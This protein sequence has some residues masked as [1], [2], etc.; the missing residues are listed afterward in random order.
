[1]T[2][3]KGNP[4]N[5]IFKLSKKGETIE[6]MKSIENIP[7]FFKYI[8]DEKI[9]SESRANVINEFIKKLQVNRYI[10]EFFSSFENESIYF[11]LS[12]IYLNST[13]KEVLKS[14]ILNLIAELRINLDI[15][16][17]IYDYLFQK[18]SLIYRSEN[19]LGKNDLHE[20]LVLLDAFLGETI[21]SLKPKN[22]FTC[23]GKGYFEVDLSKLK[24]NVG[25]SFSFILNFKLGTSA[26][27]LENPAACSKTT[28]I[29]IHFSNGHNINIDF[30]YPMF[31]LVKEIQDKYIKTL[32]VLE[33]M[34]LII[35]IVNDD[36]NNTVAYFY[37]NGENRLV[38]F[39]FKNQKIAKTD[40][41]DSIKFFNNFYGEV[42]S[43]TFLSQK[44]Y[45]FPG[46]NASEFLL[47]FKT[48]QEGYWKRKK[49]NNLIN[50]LNDF[51]SIGIEKT[52]SKTI[53]NKRPVKL[54]K[55]IEK[56]EAKVTGKLSNNLV[57]IFT[58]MN[59]CSN[60]INKN[61][62]E[63]VLGNLV[64]KFYG[65]IRPHKYYCFQ[66]RIGTLG[67][68][69]NILP[70]G[71]MFVLRPE[72]LDESN[73]LIFLGIIKDILNE[74]KHNMKYL[75]ESSFF[76]V[77]SL[78][79]EKYPKTFFTEKV[80]DEFAEIGKCLLAGNVESVTSLYF[81][82]ILLNE[83]IL[84]KYSEPLQIK[85]WN[86]ILLFCQ[87]DSSQIEVFIKM[88]RIALILRFYDRNKYNA[89]CC[90]R[91]ME[92]IKDEFLVNKTIMDP[93]MNQK[94]SSIQNILNVIISSQEPDK[95]FLLFKLLTLDLSP[96]LTEFILNIFINEF[97]KR[98]EDTSNW[99]DRFIN[100]LIENKYQA[101]IANTF[102]HSLPELK[103]SLLTLITEINS[104]LVKLNKAVH[105][106]AIEDIIMQS[107][108]PQDNFYAKSKIDKSSTNTNTNSN[109]ANSNTNIAKTNINNNN[110]KKLMN[111]TI[112]NSKAKDLEEKVKVKNTSKDD[113]QE[114]KKMN[115]I[116]TKKMSNLISQFELMKNKIPGIAPPKPDLQKTA[117]QNQEHLQKTATQNPEQ[118][119]QQIKN[120][121][122]EIPDNN[123]K[124][125]Y[126]NNK[127]E[128]IIFNDKVY[129]EYVEKLYELL[130]LWAVN[131]VQNTI[132]SQ[133]D[134]KKLTVESPIALEFLL[135]LAL[136]I[137]DILFYIKCIR[138]IHFLSSTPINAYK[139]LLNP[140]IVC[141]LSDIIFKYYKAKDKKESQCFEMIK[142][143]LLNI[144]MNNMAY[145]ENNKTLSPYPLDKV[146]FLFL[147][148]DKKIFQIKTKNQKDQVL[149]FLNDFLLEFLTTFKIKY[150]RS[151]DLNVT[152]GN[153]Q[154]SPTNFYLKNYLI[155]MTH[156]FKFSFHYKHDEIIKTEGLTF[157][158]QSP[159]INNYLLFYLTGMR[160]NPLK[161]EKMI[162]QWIDYP[163][164]DDMYR[165]FS[166]IINI[167]YSTSI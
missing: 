158:A 5:E 124:L 40:T 34:N 21:N 75:A 103:I 116:S 102:L 69:N 50:L 146:D 100:V 71:E 70:I 120:L 46:V 77:L 161:G 121:Y 114:L 122:E 108:L 65:N 45:G 51:D 163:F 129:F 18:L 36:K 12:K 35:N 44:D 152:K 52:K 133:L 25:C 140:K 16:K 138:I 151:M 20:Y 89:I 159:G 95:A 91:H 153:M 164:F 165:R 128:V 24:L 29:D 135:S 84:L 3:I 64:L 127:G 117:T 55:K 31:L 30:E 119:S 111:S 22:Y 67:I 82:H 78:F 38:A 13:S 149:D 167:I 11:I 125:N 85:F 148:G 166:F 142:N 162:E 139:M 106:K 15:N 80:L 7:L 8:K 97:Q 105:F 6:E 62:V 27:A 42:S 49:I 107:L 144:F 92:L 145:S 99:K 143:I 37:T 83:K 150:E 19:N 94:L 47:Q 141:F 54:E 88:N 63:N 4:L 28:L 160:L 96:C 17:N 130:L 154:A 112:V 126:E 98:K 33:W 115:T 101:I 110:A 48:Y 147:W 23:S 74:R 57:F 68:I 53:F 58:P 132:I 73:F 113:S 76:E 81:E 90:K 109:N 155:L 131:Q 60:D 136:D 66:K 79:V 123:Y 157:I 156:F 1:M 93:P 9:P 72:L 134:F 41:I 14:S 56:E 61:V 10:S 87:L 26:L 104:R 2:D 32:P 118:K 59:Y 43:I 39:P 86:H 137:D